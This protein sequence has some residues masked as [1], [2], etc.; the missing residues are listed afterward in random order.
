MPI[1]QVDSV[2]T[3]PAAAGRAAVFLDRDGVINRALVREGKPYPPASLAEFEILP[4]V[5]AACAR[6]KA[7]GFLLVVAT[8]Q[9]DVGRGTMPRAVVEEIHRFMR[10]TLSLDAVEVCYHPGKGASDCNCRKPKPGMLVHAARELGIDLKT[11][12]MI[13]D[14]WRDIDC[15]QAAG[16]RTI[17]IDRGYSEELRQAPDFRARDL[18]EAT[19]LILA[20]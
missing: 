9:P 20:R 4:E 18:A 6:L 10:K 16:C 17:F 11:S 7:A 15:G 3:G 1:I 14:R 12:W 19:D 2:V 13:G 5:P 8:N